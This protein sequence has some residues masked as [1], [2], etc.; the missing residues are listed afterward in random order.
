MSSLLSDLVLQ[1]PLGGQGITVYS[2]N[3]CLCLLGLKHAQLLYKKC[4]FSWVSR[5]KIFGDRADEIS[6][7]LCVK[8]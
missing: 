8:T 1:W 4:V 3:C 6:G 2:V 7:Y 5:Q